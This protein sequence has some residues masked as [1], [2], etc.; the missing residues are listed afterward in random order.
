[1]SILID[2]RHHY[3]IYNDYGTSRR[4]GNCRLRIFHH[5]DKNVVIVTNDEQTT[6][7][8]MTS[9][10]E[11][12]ASE[13]CMEYNIPRES[14]IWFENFPDYKDG[15]SGT[16]SSVF[17]PFELVE[18]ELEG[19]FGFQNPVRRRVSQE[20]VEFKINTILSD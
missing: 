19:D 11:V 18:F 2:K 4:S 7:T 9:H 14:L 16:E 13:I 12:L 1:M 3:Q 8:S 17:F 20:F 15:I 6:G 5:E 10:A